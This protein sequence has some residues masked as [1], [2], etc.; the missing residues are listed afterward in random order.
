MGWERVGG[1]FWVGD[2]VVALGGITARGDERLTFDEP[3]DVLPDEQDTLTVRV[4]S[5]GS[6]LALELLGSGDN[7]F[8][9][10]IS[11]QLSECRPLQQCRHLLPTTSH[12]QH[13]QQHPPPP[14]LDSREKRCQAEK[15]ECAIG[16]PE[17]GLRSP[18]GG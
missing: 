1:G 14:K 12:R 5:D 3:R 15:S 4:S 11:C 16:A 2:L 17:N 13:E 18:P 10:R 7:I 9:E 6:N 8:G